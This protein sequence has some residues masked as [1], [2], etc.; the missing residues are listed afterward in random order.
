VA[1]AP[2]NAE[3]TIRRRTVFY[4]SGYDPRGPGH[5]HG[6]Y[7]A[8]AARQEAVNGLR[9]A[10]GPRHGG[11]GIEASWTVR[12]PATQTHYRFLRYDDLMR[13]R[14]SRSAPAVVRDICYCFFALLGRGVTLKVARVSWP[15]A[16]TLASPF[17]LL[18]GGIVAALVAGL[19][20]ATVTTWW[21]GAIAALA[22]F[23]GLLRL[24]PRL[25]QRLGSLWL[26]RTFAFMADQ[27][28]GR[29]ADMEERIDTFAA[30]IADSLA[31]GDSDEV[32]V[33][34]HS[35]GAQ[36]AV[37]ALAA[38]LARLPGREVPV[39]LLTLG[40]TI[41]VLGLQP[42]ARAFRRDLAAL[43]ADARVTWIDFS[44]AIDGACFALTDPL[45]ACGLAQPDPAAPK[46]KLL[47]TRFPRLFGPERY[48]TIR[49]DFRLAHFLYLMATEQA[50]DYDYFL[51]TGGDMSLGRRY[52]H[53]DGV[54][55]FNRFRLGRP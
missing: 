50:G 8:E 6:L 19:A 44:A 16:I 48:A 45:A 23:A 27:G 13:A 3:A 1:A 40:Q 41:P 17:A 12:G 2:D 42:K 10:V 22:F 29:A 18:M 51:I 14:W 20:V 53:L 49:R 54:T 30:R 34:G 5:Y 43:A 31:A 52:A 37:A 26:A 4:I 7:R 24:R 28:G 21:F 15:F 47:S 55:S 39:S 35:A 33:V 32:L 46:P 36:I 38:A 25:E 9:L 11:D